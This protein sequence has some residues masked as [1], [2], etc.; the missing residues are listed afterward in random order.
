MG[1]IIALIVGG[2]AGWLASIVMNRNASMGIFWNIVVGCIGSVIGNAL[3]GPLLGVR[4][5]V[6]QFSL[7]GLLIA[8]VGAVVL[9]AI[10]N[11]VQRNTVR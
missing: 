2:I 9:L 5:S 8:F 3:A 7:V 4:G 11:L 1:W 6:Q 10:V